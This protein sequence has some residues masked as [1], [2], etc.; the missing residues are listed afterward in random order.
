[1]LAKELE[2]GRGTGGDGNIKGRMMELWGL[3]SQ[4][5]SE[6]D[7]DRNGRGGEGQGLDGWAVVDDDAMERLAKVRCHLS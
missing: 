6:R 4:V 2:G 7:K 3:L 1:M 5:K